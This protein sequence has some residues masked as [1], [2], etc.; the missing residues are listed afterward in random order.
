MTDSSSWTRALDQLTAAGVKVQLYHGESPVYIHA[1]VIS[2]DAGTPGQRAFI[3]SENFSAGSMEYN[4]ELGLVTSS[5]AILT[6][7]N[8][9]LAS[10]FSG[11]AT[12]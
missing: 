3:G 10:D 11:N 6:P 9:T 1:K 8:A 2:V 5:P 7:L 4:R 12:T